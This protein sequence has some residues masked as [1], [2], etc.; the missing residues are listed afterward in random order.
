MKIATYN[1]R[2]LFLHHEGEA[3]PRAE[4]RALTRMIALVDADV[5]ILQEVGSSVSLER[6]NDHLPAPYPY[7]GL[8]EGNSD[9]SIH[10]GVLGRHAHTLTGHTEQRLPD[11]EG[12]VLQGY[13]GEAQAQTGELTALRMSRDILR[14]DL[15]DYPLSLFGV[16]LKSRTERRWQHVSAL[17]VRA[18]EVRLLLETA[19]SWRRAEP[20][21]IQ[22]LLGDFNDTP[23]SD[24]LAPLRDDYVD[25]FADLLRGT[26]KRPSTYWPK[27]RMRID[28]IYVSRDA[29][30]RV[31]EP[32]IHAGSM[33]QQASDH[34][35]VSVCLDA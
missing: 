22:L 25:V 21:R 35:P 24:A 5:L 14:V 33:A 32:V 27:R 2:N 9:R 15:T 18:A 20:G 7:A 30:A 8:L 23:S 17:T 26:R 1:V 28:Q 12:G 31:H 11:G 16:H 29:R 10:L 19:Q 4:L 6:L 34:Y 3:K 13:A